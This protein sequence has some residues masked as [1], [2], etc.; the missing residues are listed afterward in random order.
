MI[1]TR[2]PGERIKPFIAAYLLI[3]GIVILTRALRPRP[4]KESHAHLAPLGFA[5]GFFDSI[6]GGGWGPIVVG[7]L[8]ARGNEPRATIAPVAARLA[9]RVPA[10]P[11]MIA[12]GAIVVVLSVRT[13]AQATG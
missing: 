12:V 8:L 10:R 11:L 6:G 5:G 2:V 4:A 7:T 3:M 9:N 1:L 13:I